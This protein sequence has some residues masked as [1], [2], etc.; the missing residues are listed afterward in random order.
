MAGMPRLMSYFVRGLVYLLPIGLTVWVFVAAFLWIDGLFGFRWHGLGMLVLV[1]G[2]TLFG[3]VLSNFLGAKLLRWF[4][5]LIDHLPLARA[6]HT[7]SRDL[8]N[9]FVGKERRFN[10]PVRVELAPGVSTLGFLTRESMDDYGMRDTVGVYL[11]QA[12]NFAGQLV[13]VPADRVHTIDRT[14]GEVM[15]LIVSGGVTQP[16]GVQAATEDPK[17]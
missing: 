10:V 12:Y 15:A 4:D 3:F 11:P 6:L 5:S 9:A 7:S 17:G 2:I 8:L 14:P 1:S 13:L 16:H